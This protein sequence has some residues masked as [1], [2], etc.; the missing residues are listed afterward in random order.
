MGFKNGGLAVEELEAA[1][2]PGITE[3]AGEAFIFTR[4]NPELVRIAFGNAGMRSGDGFK[5]VPSYHHAVTMPASLA[6]ELARLLLEKY[7]APGTAGGKS[8]SP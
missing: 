4:D 6:I 2:R 7:A 1:F 8:S 5:R 3:F